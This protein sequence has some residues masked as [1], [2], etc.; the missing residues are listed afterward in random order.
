MVIIKNQ[1]LAAYILLESLVALAILACITSILLGEFDRQ[2]KILQESQ[3]RQEA[4]LL[5]T[6]AINAKKKELRLNGVSVSIKEHSG[7]VFVYHEK[8]ELLHA[9]KE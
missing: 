2:R 3:E 6:M 8:E 4:L 5:A 9:L 1:K 7:G